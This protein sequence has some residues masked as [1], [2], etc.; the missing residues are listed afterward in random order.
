MSRRDDPKRDPGRATRRPLVPIVKPGRPAGVYRGAE[1]E[2]EPV[3]TRRQAGL[4]SRT[5]W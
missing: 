2:P 3:N 1:L 5:L 4:R